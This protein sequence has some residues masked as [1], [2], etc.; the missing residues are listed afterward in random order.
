M[1]PSRQTADGP[2]PPASVRHHGR[3]SP[4][5]R[6]VAPLGPEGFVIKVASTGSH[7]VLGEHTEVFR[8][9]FNLLHKRIGG[10]RSTAKLRRI[11]ITIERNGEI[12]EVKIADDGGG[13]PPQVV[14][15]LFRGPA[16]AGAVHG[17]GLAMHA[18]SW[19]AMAA[20]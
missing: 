16:T 7:I 8:V 6:S 3:G 18:N 12:T 19:S 13:L 5:R 1:R 10:A 9:L 17:H 4:R 11:E 15:K 20:R 14:A 2:Q